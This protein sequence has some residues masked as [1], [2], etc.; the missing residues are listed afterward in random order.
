M[1]GGF[2]DGGVWLFAA[3]L[4][5]GL[6]QELRRNDG[7]STTP[8][9]GCSGPR[10]WGRDDTAPRRPE[11]LPKG[12]GL[13]MNRPFWGPLLAEAVGRR[14]AED[15]V[16]EVPVRQQAEPIRHAETCPCNRGR[17]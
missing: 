11:S 10:P 9:R 14:R 2:P 8:S 13:R 5:L 7:R 16:A 1:R 12:P 3:V 17:Q 4:I 6:N 15:I